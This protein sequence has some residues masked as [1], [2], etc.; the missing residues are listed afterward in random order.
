[1]FFRHGSDLF[2]ALVE[3]HHTADRAKHDLSRP[4]A[5]QAKM[6]PDPR[7]F[8]FVFSSQ[9]ISR[10]RAGWPGRFV[11]QMPQKRQNYGVLWDFQNGW[12]WH[13]PNEMMQLEDN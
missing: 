11:T 4:K 6:L 1:M 12:D 9:K 2:S 3:D 7:R 13:N 8:L 10:Y 5:W